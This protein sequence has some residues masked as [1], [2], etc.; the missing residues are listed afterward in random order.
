MQH[1][2]TEREFREKPVLLPVCRARTPPA[3]FPSEMSPDYDLQSCEAPCT[4][5][6]VAHLLNGRG[7]QP[8]AQTRVK[9]SG[10]PEPGPE[11]E[12]ACLVCLTGRGIQPTAS[13]TV[14][15]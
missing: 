5:T 11:P 8:L 2:A 12:T 7:D 14:H 13:G 1:A 6:T 3:F 15:R 9:L 4:E 10:F